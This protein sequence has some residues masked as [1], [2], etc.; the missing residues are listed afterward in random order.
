L[1]LDSLVDI[2]SNNVGILIILAAFMALFALIRP[3]TPQEREQATA[4]DPPPERLE[5]PWSHATNKEQIYFTIRDGRL[6]HLDLRP[7]YRELAKLPSD[8]GLKPVTISRSGLDIRF[9]PVTN[10]IYCLE[11]QPESGAGETWTAARQGGSSW[12][13]ARARY[14][15][16]DFVYFFWVT[17][18]S[19]ELFRTVRDRLRE[20]DVEVGWKPVQPDAP[21]ELCNGFQGSSAFRP[22]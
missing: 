14:A 12:A 7:F 2:V 13:A 15:A 11:F 19:F 16:R 22:Q 21:L 6:L 20:Q 4:T 3:L 5:V 18:D 8:R 17:G 10:Q 1:S 9:F